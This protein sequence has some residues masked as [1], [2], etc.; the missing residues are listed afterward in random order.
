MKP[1]IKPVIFVLIALILFG[2]TALFA[3]SAVTESE[4]TAPKLIK[5]RVNLFHFGSIEMPE[6]HKGFRTEGF[7]DAWFGYLESSD[8][9]F[10]INWAA[11][12]VQ[13]HFE[14]HKKKFLWIKAEKTSNETIKLG[15]LRLKKVKLLVARID[16]IEFVASIKKQSDTD[17]FMEVVRSYQRDK[18]D[19]CRGLPFKKR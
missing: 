6:N 14:N 7:I 2:A 19:D 15:L 3:Q 13:S 11:G 9:N 8:G 16:D 1:K 18:C 17:I 10:K 4:S 5:K 12:L